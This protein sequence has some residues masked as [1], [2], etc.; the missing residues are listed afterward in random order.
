MGGKKHQDPNY[1]GDS[2]ATVEAVGNN[3]AANW[4]TSAAADALA[5]ESPQGSS[6]S[7]IA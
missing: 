5:A 1:Q 6:S 4:N 7:N 3:M 2:F